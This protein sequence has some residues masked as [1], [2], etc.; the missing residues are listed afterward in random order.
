MSIHDAAD[1]NRPIPEWTEQGHLTK[2]GPIHSEHV[3][4]L[5][6]PS[7]AN[8]YVIRSYGTTWYAGMA[9]GEYIEALDLDAAKRQAVQ[10]VINCLERAL[11]DLRNYQEREHVQQPTMAETHP[12]AH[13]AASAKL[14]EEYRK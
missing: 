6:L 1:T 13:E 9:L 4:N 8:P 11:A 2:M 5:N 7:V 12:L 10:L 3:L 14:V